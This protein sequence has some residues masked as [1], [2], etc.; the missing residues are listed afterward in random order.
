ME[1]E[2]QNAS[3][4]QS[5]G[6]GWRHHTA[7]TGT[8]FW[9]GIRLSKRIRSSTLTVGPV[10]ELNRM[11]WK[12]LWK[13][14]RRI[15]TTFHHYLKKCSWLATHIKAVSLRPGIMNSLTFACSPPLFLCCV[16]VFL[17]A[18]KSATVFHTRKLP[19]I[20]DCF[21]NCAGGGLERRCW[22]A[23]VTVTWFY[24]RRR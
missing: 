13:F 5:V 15:Q 10:I 14:Q 18:V 1:R 23:T 22:L 19:S 6:S 9:N 4:F 11:K 3:E 20:S 24:M 12:T 8:S 17:G 2:N 7:N 16:C 21:W